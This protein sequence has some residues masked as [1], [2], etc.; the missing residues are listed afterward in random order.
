MTKDVREIIK[1]VT[2]AVAAVAAIGLATIG[3]ALAGEPLGEKWCSSMKI[4]FMAG[5]AQGD[6]FAA[7]VEAG[8]QQA[9]QDTGAELSVVYSGWNSEKIVQQMREA[10]AQGVDGIVTYGFPGT[11]ALTPIA[12]EASKAGVL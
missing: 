8:G 4:R 10:I 5:G 12:E 6:T 3:P 9:A 1:M 11:A 7:V 2:G